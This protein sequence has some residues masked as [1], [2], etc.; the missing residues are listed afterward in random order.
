MDADKGANIPEGVVNIIKPIIIYILK[1]LGIYPAISLKWSG[2]LKEVGWFRSHE[3]GDSV[4][5]DGNPLP[6]I[7][8]PAI[9]FLQRRV[10]KDMTVFEY[11]CGSGTLWWSSKVREIVSVEHDKDWYQKILA[12]KPPNVSIYNI[13]LETDGKYSKK[14]AEWTN[15]FDIIIIDGRDRVNCARNSLKALKSDGVIIWDN[16][17]RSEYQEGYDLLLKNGFKKIEFVGMCP[18]VNFKTET[19]IYYRNNNI[20]GI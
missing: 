9:D 12:V 6:W 4:D 14:V 15:T 17:D 11:G 1:V 2:P 5:A 7:T 13:A 16:S 8:Y 3:E 19:S 18:V 20:L 10:N